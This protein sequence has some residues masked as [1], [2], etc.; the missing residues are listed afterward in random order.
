MPTIA[1]L[2]WLISILK[3]RGVKVIPYFVYIY[4]R[5]ETHIKVGIVGGSSLNVNY[6]IWKE[7]LQPVDVNKGKQQSTNSSQRIGL[8]NCYYNC[9]V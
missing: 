4:L 2:S 8:R 1:P 6:T 9:S 3:I 5:I 7:H